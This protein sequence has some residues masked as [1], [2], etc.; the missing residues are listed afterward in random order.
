MFDENNWYENDSQGSNGDNSDN[1]NKGA[2]TYDSASEEKEVNGQTQNASAGNTQESG[3][4]IQ[5]PYQQFMNQS[6]QDNYVWNHSPQQAQQNVPPARPPKRKGKVRAVLAVVLAVAIVG[7][8]AYIVTG[9][10]DKIFSSNGEKPQIGT[11]VT[12][13]ETEQAERT[14]V[15]ISDNSAPSS[16]G[17]IILTDVSEIVDDVMPSVVAITS[18]AL[19]ES[20]NYGWGYWSSGSSE[21]Q[22]VNAGAGSGIIVQQTDKELLIVTNNHVVEDASS[23]SVQFVDGKSVEATVKGTDSE[24]DLA[25]VAIPLDTIEDSTLKSIKKATI[26]SS[27]NMKVGEGVIAIGNALGYGQSV[28]TGIISVMDAKITVDGV[29]RE[30]MI[31]TDAAINGGNSG[32]ALLNSRGEV[33]GI[34]FAKRFYFSSTS[35]EGMGYA[36]P[37]SSATDVIND[38]M[39]QETRTKVEESKRGTLG[40]TGMDITDDYVSQLG[41]PEGVMITKLTEGGAAEKAGIQVRDII[42]AIGGK[43]VAS[44]E[45]LKEEL[46]YYEKG[47]TVTVTIQYAENRSYIAKDVTLTLQ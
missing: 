14:T 18:R 7:T 8:G 42:T 44:M 23:L 43:K 46:A 35:V 28:T 38:L 19:I 2:S 40:I 9:G 12:D 17:Q 1:E 10:F 25:V 24:R 31:Q 36:I 34:N 21:K 3:D 41:M 20:G 45:E 39:N 13:R 47:E 30:H 11:T 4:N 22:E 32:G 15:E 27:D 29:T 33:I 26:G 6:N 16:T 5:R 37:I